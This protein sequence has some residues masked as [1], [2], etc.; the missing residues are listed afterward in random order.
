ME[1]C[2]VCDNNCG[3]CKF[4]CNC[5]TDVEEFEKK[6]SP[7]KNGVESGV[8]KKEPFR[9]LANDFVTDYFECAKGVSNGR[10]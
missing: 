8:L 7:I 9:N 1:A 6:K 2:K 3:Y 10:D 4:N 5:L